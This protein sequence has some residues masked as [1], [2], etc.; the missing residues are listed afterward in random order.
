MTFFSVIVKETVAEFF[1]FKNLNNTGKVLE[2]LDL[3]DEDKWWRLG[4]KIEVDD[5]MLKRISIKCGNR[6]HE[7]RG[8]VID[9]I[10]AS[11]PFETIHQLKDDF[12]EMKAWEID[13]ILG[14]QLGL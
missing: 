4:I 5:R 1:E 6:Q 7:L 8:D 9:V 10:L 12:E 13:L 3:I 14:E 2:M 11:H